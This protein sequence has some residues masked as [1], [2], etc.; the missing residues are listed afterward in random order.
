[1]EITHAL[2]INGYDVK[3]STKYK[4]F[5]K[6]TQIDY[7]EIEICNQLPEKGDTNND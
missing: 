3:S 7:F 1:M 4:E 6:D 5:P 2:L